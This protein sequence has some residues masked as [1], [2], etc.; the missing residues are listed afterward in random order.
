[1]T[2]RDDNEP[3]CAQEIGVGQGHRRQCSR[4]AVEDG[5][6]RQHA[7]DPRR[8]VERRIMQLQDLVADSVRALHEVVND[9]EHKDRVK[10]AQIVLDRTGYGPAH[11]VKL[12]DLRREIEAELDDDDGGPEPA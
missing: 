11:T 10:A 7:N 2:K 5:Y 6:C 8:Q 12:D 4:K 3:Q 1:V 9:V